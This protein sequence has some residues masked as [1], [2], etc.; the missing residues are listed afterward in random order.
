MSEKGSR[1]KAVWVASLHTGGCSACAQSVAAL[2]APRYAR[3][4]R[5]Q[6][7]TLARSPRHSDVLLLCGALTEQ[8]RAT[9]TP[10]IAGIPRP[11]ALVAVGDCALNGCV[12][13]GSAA[14]SVPLVQA[15]N[16]NVEI[17]GCPP[18]PE[19]IIAAIG[20]AQ[21][22][23]AGALPTTDAAAAPRLP[24]TLPEPEEASATSAPVRPDLAA[25]LE[26]AGSDW[27]DDELDNE[28]DTEDGEL[29]PYDM[30]PSPDGTAQRSTGARQ[31]EEKLR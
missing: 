30:R 21:R 10:L 28:L 16:V 24:A 14:L 18:A 17:A 19:A 1:R 9:L 27:D 4:L 26:A 29:P 12:F 23:L 5:R 6:G 8:A 15:F 3:S 31:A 13:A 2:A 20:E 7:I 22:L 11:N 25:L